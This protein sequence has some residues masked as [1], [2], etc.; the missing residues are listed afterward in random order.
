MTYSLSHIHEVYRSL[1]SV[2]IAFSTHGDVHVSPVDG[3]EKNVSI[4]SFDFTSYLQF[5][6]FLSLNFKKS[7]TDF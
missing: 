1:L 2:S 7:F 6:K 5:L 3:L 4:L